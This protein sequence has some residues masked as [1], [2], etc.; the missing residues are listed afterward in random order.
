M[1]VLCSIELQFC[2][3]DRTCVVIW[4][5][6]EP[7]WL[8]CSRFVRFRIRSHREGKWKY[9]ELEL[10]WS[11]GELPAEIIQGY[12]RF[13]IPDLDM[14]GFY[15]RA[16]LFFYCSNNMKCSLQQTSLHRLWINKSRLRP[17]KTDMRGTEEMM[18]N[19]LAIITLDINTCVGLV[20]T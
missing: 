3:E 19:V 4:Y 14:S 11:H 16:I 9:K 17:R 18:K 10:I 7:V 20:S 13:V 12:F 5:C 15:T 2:L 8:C 1:L 6:L